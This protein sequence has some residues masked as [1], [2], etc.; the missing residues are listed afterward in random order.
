[1]SV[2][3]GFIA[4]VAILGICLLVFGAIAVFVL[5]GRRDRN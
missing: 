1:M 4:L 3:F 5:L 2:S